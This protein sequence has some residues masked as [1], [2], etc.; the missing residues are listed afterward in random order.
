MGTLAPLDIAVI[1]DKYGVNE[2][3]AT[4]NDVYELKDVNAQGT[5]Y[6]AIW[7]GG[8]VDEMR[9]SGSRN[10]TLDLRPA[11]LEYEQGGGG[12]VSYAYGIHG[13]FVI[14][15]GAT[16]ENATSGSG[17]DIL[18][19]NEGANVLAGNAGTDAISSFGG[20]D[21]LT[22]G[23]GNDTLSGGAGADQFWFDHLSGRDVVTDFTPGQD[24]LGFSGNGPKA[25]AELRISDLACG[26]EAGALVTWGDGAQ[27]VWLK[28]V[29]SGSLGSGDFVFV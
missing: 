7:D 18:N 14:A 2:E 8:G 6:Q 11:T 22:G 1:Q 20:D 9:Y 23:S 13:G 28:A 17:D 25:F 24:H 12:R 16:I 5:F 21:L 3:W 10:A 19:G 15:N 26:G 29:T 4:G 27:E